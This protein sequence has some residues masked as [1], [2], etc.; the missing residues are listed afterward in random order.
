MV[1]PLSLQSRPHSTTPLLLTTHPIILFFFFVMIN[2]RP[3]LRQT[4][5]R[6][7]PRQTESLIPHQH[8]R[9]TLLP[10]TAIKPTERL[11]A[12]IH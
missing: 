4:Q 7:H 3:L 1:C 10:P 8:G 2:R 9:T 12:T 5:R 11:R 6:L